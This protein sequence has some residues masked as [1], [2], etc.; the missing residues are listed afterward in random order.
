[1]E[2]AYEVSERR[3]CK[4]LNINRTAYRYKPKKD[5]QAIKYTFNNKLKLVLYQISFMMKKDQG[6]ENKRYV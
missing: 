5:E 2:K 3:S 1:M 4:V 6:F